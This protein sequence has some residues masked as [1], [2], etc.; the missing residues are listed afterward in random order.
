MEKKIE[1]VSP[2]ETALAKENIT[3]QIIE[4]LKTDYLGL[5][6]NGLEDKDGFNKVELARKHCKSLR[7]AAV[8]ICKL[9]RE[10]AVKI[11]KDWIAKEKEV[12]AAIDITETHLENESNRIKYEEKRILFEA[13]QRSK[14]P[15]RKNRLLEIGVSVEDEKI[16]LIDD[17]QFDTFFND[18]HYKIL[19]EKELKLKEEEN[20]RLEEEREKQRLEN[21]RLKKENEA[22]EKALQ[23]ERAKAKAEQEKQDA[24]LKAEKEKAEKEAAKQKSIADAKI[25]EEREAK[26]KAEAELKAIADAEEKIKQDKIKQDKIDEE[27][28]KKAL[29]APDKEKLKEW[30]DK[31]FIGLTPEVGG[32]SHKTALEIHVKFQAFQKWAKEQIDLIK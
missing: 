24:I 14:L 23:E 2:I 31:I 4:K 25:K 28:R 10:D 12:V 1:N 27:N 26:E 8:R 18:L 19:A 16:L 9:G 13:I 7:T 3:N 20:K 32:E 30:V 5:K 17:L 15:T 6:I 21:E 11:Q 29:L 22:K